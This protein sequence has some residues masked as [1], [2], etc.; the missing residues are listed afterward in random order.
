LVVLG[1]Y[2]L[3]LFIGPVPSRPDDFHI[4]FRYGVTA[5]NVLDTREGKFTKDLMLDPPITINLT[6]TRQELD[7]VWA[8]I[9]RNSFYDL[10]DQDPARAGSVTPAVT[11]VLFV[12]AEGYPDKQVSMNDVRV[13]YTL[14]ERRFLRIVWKIREITESRPEYRA[15]P[16]PR[17]GYA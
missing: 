17:G 8:Y 11:Y 12:H 5:K 6:L 4:V 9:H 16:G 10:E 7:T 2:N 13:G 14:S 1:Y 15:L 3:R